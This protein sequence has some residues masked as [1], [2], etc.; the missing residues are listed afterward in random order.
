MGSNNIDLFFKEPSEP[1]QIPGENGILYLLRR[2]ILTCLG[3]NPNEPHKSICYQALFPAGMALL[4]GIDLLGKFAAGSDGI[5][6]AGCRFKEFLKTYGGLSEPGKDNEILWQLRNA[7]LHS[8]GLYSEKKKFCLT[9][10][11]NDSNLIIENNGYCSVNLWA[12]HQMLEKAIE[13]YRCALNAS[14]NQGKQLLNNFDAVFEKYGCIE[15]G[16]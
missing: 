5:G 14:C 15:I 2:D 9:M 3:K 13:N 8:F 16:K 6:K 1:P 12:L 11:E 10:T 4:A 7:L